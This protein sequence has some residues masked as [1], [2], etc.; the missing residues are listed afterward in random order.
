MFFVCYWGVLIGD[1]QSKYFGFEFGNVT[2][3]FGV[4]FFVVVGVVCVVVGVVG[5]VGICWY[6]CVGGLPVRLDFVFLSWK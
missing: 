6:C 2:I 3:F 4:C 5:I 1:V